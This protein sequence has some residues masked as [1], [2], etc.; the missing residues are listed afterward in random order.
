MPIVLREI[1]YADNP[2]A[3]D[4][5]A[6]PLVL[7]QL[8]FQ[9][10]VV[11]LTSYGF[12]FK[13][14][15]YNT[16]LMRVMCE[17]PSRGAAGAG[18]NA[19]SQP[20]GKGLNWVSTSTASGDFLPKNLNT[21]IVEQIWRSDDGDVNNVILRCDTEI[22]QG[23]FTDTLAI[24]NHNFSQAANIQFEGSS[25]PS[26]STSGI[27][28]A[29]QWTQDN[30]FWISPDLP[31]SGFR[32]WRIVID[33]PTNTDNFVSVGTIVFGVSDIFSGEQNTDVIQFGWKDFADKVQTEGFTTV[34]NSRA[35]KK[36]MHLDFKSID[37]DF[38]NFSILRKLTTVYRTTHKCLYIPTPSA[39]DQNIT[40]KFAVF[41][42][43]VQLNQESHNYKSSDFVDQGID[44]DE[45]Q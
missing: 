32:Y 37:A 33:D 4:P 27:S 23:V 35:L 44:L 13:A 25:D 14:V 39:T 28:I 45:S 42:K 7:G 12:Q 17:F 26:F 22:N 18:N 20:K 19:W 6:S 43:Q 9:F 8:G 30:M 40:A 29:L 15:I 10:N 3:E 34:A 11:S 2:Y 36:T 38:P 24:L 16:N 41:S 21:D 31:I 5:Y 1:G